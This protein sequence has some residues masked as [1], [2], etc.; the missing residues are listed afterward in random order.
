M[1]LF[2]Y[3]DGVFGYP[4]TSCTGYPVEA[5]FTGFGCGGITTIGANGHGLFL[6][7]IWVLIW[8]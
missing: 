8:S 3:A 2:S 5:Y 4:L 6:R 1:L 7:G